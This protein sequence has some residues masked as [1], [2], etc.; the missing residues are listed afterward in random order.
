MKKGTCF[1]FRE[2]YAIIPFEI[3]GKDIPM[4]RI[5]SVAGSFYFSFA[6]FSRANLGLSAM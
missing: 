2:E 3:K 5:V 6:Y 1:T 4:K